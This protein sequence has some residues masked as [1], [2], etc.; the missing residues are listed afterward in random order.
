MKFTYA[1][2]VM[3]ALSIACAGSVQADEIFLNFTGTIFDNPEKNISTTTSFASPVR[4][5]LE[6]MAPGATYDFTFAIDEN[7]VPSYKGDNGWTLTGTYNSSISLVNGR[8]GT[9]TDFDGWELRFFLYSQ[10]PS[11]GTNDSL[12]I[13][14]HAGDGRT[15]FFYLVHNAPEDAWDTPHVFPTIEEFNQ[16]ASSSS[17]LFDGRGYHRGLGRQ[18]YWEWSGGSGFAA[19]VPEPASLVLLG[20]GSF[21]FLRRR[22]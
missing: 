13:E 15:A 8:A 10:H 4:E 16:P 21:A 5:Y 19:E 22:R 2:A 6:S 1:L 12:Q 14:M 7:A 3:S 18:I 20:L 9:H 17:A 11:K